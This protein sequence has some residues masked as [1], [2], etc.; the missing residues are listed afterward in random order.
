LREGVRGRG[1]WGWQRLLPL[2][3]SRKGRGRIPQ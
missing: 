3:P 2:T 1:L